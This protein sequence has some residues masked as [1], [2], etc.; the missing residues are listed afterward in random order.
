MSQNLGHLYGK[1]LINY[2]PK[3]IDSAYSENEELTLIVQPNKV[4]EV[5]FFLKNHSSCQFKSLTDIC[6]VDYPEREQ[7]FEVV[8]N[9]L[10][11]TYNARIR[12]KTSIEE[13]N[14]LDSVVSLYPSAGWLEREV[15]D[16]FG[17]FFIN[18][19]DLR[20]LLT[21]YGFEGYPLRKDFPLTGYIETRFSESEKRVIIEPIQMTQDF[22]Y[23]EFSNPWKT[24]NIK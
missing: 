3:A 7:R 14:A 23:F 20:R 9:L 11:T 19:P 10:S 6:G 5:L 1:Q 18:N 15:W 17:V 8:Y 4:Y 12:V 2:L 13:T 24:S 21:D 22:R 16:I